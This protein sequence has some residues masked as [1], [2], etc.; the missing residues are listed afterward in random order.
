MEKN[1]R[2]QLIVSRFLFA[3]VVSGAVFNFLD[4]F[5]FLFKSTGLFDF[6]TFWQVSIFWVCLEFIN[7]I[8]RKI[9]TVSLPEFVRMYKARMISDHGQ[10]TFDKYGV[11][12]MLYG[13]NLVLFLLFVF[14][15]IFLYSAGSVSFVQLILGTLYEIWRDPLRVK[16]YKSIL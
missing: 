4:I 5:L 6:R 11:Y 3:V 15:S 1:I 16:D 14:L 2:R 8:L 12:G 13:M 7:Y 9:P 10:A